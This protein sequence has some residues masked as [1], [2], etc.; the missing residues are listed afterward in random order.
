MSLFRMLH[1][2]KNSTVWVLMVS[3]IAI[4][5]FDEAVTDFLSFYNP[6]ARD[7][8][9]S[10]GFSFPPMFTF[11]IWLGGLIVGILVCFAL[12]PLVKRGGRIIRVFTIVLG[13]LMI[14][15]SLL[16]ILG[17]AYSGSL[18]PG[19]WSSPLLLLA[20]LLVVVRGFR[21]TWA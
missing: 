5:V 9:E 11:E 1:E 6:I 2:V 12:T 21:G 3:A 13:I 15:N 20:A 8:R 4:H 7:I 14:A 16:H 19:F 17:S 10:L 18:L